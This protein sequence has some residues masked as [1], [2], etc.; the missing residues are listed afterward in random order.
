MAHG[1][2]WAEAVLKSHF[3]AFCRQLHAKKLFKFCDKLAPRKLDSLK[4]TLVLAVGVKYSKRRIKNC[5]KIECARRPLVQ[6]GLVEGIDSQYGNCD[7]DSLS[8]NVTLSK[9][10]NRHILVQLPNQIILFK[11]AFG[12]MVHK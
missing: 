5:R 1:E 9:S 8:Y 11:Q 4:H 7:K 2:E 6:I 3:K 10:Q 12:S